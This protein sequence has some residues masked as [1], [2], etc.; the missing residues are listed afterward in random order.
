MFKAGDEFYIHDMACS[1]L[2]DLNM[3]AHLTKHDDKNSTRKNDVVQQL[4]NLRLTSDVHTVNEQWDSSCLTGQLENIQ[5]V[6]YN[7]IN[8]IK[9]SYLA[10]L[11]V[12]SEKSKQL[13]QL[14]SE[15]PETLIRSRYKETYILNRDWIFNPIRAAL[16]NTS[17]VSVQTRT[18]L[19][20]YAL[21]FLHNCELHRPKFACNIPIS[22]KY[23]RLLGIFMGEHELYKDVNV[24]FYLYLLLKHYVQD[25]KQID[26][27]DFGIQIPGIISFYDYYKYALET[28]ESTSYGNRLYTLFILVPIQQHCPQIYRQLLWSDFVHIFRFCQLDSIQ[29]MPFKYDAFMR[30]Y[31]LNV[32]I[33]SL[34]AN[35]LFADYHVISMC[36]F[37]YFICLNHLNVFLYDQVNTSYLDFNRASHNRPDELFAFKKTLFCQFYNSTNEVR[38]GCFF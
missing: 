2:F 7:S 36:P 8:L 34:Y 33:L 35:A 15:I 16:S 1:F 32:N 11:Q 25:T 3:W 9:S 18:S 22:I 27:C 29:H 17:Q 20:L 13:N 31:E 37:A 5:A 24:S 21:A 4:Q 10:D 26:Q 23:T 30:P 14:D 28:Y 38:Y 12:N 6:F 19:V